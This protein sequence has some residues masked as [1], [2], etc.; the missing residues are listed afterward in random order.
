MTETADLDK[1]IELLNGM[2]AAAT[3][4]KEKLGITDRLLKCYAMKLKHS[5]SGKGGKFTDLPSQ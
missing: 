4:I 3:G 2:L 5:D 1:T